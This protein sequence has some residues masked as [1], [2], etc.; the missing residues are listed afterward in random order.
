MKLSQ[1]VKYSEESVIIFFIIP[2][3][4]V[5]FLMSI[6]F[7]AGSMFQIEGIS[8]RHNKACSTYARKMKL[9]QTVK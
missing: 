6:P 8:S 2:K 4:S 5:A 3:M 7:A 1:T 9:K